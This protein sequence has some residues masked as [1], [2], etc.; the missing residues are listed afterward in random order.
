[1][2][3]AAFQP[4]KRAGMPDDIGEAVAYLANNET[5]G[6]ITGTDLVIDGGS[7]MKGISSSADE[8]TGKS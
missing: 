1:M 8:V 7:L 2:Q 5:A 3:A 6:F 4:L